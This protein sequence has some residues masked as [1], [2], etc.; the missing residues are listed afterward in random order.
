MRLNRKTKPEF[1][2]A[3]TV[4]FQRKRVTKQKDIFEC[5]NCSLQVI[6]VSNVPGGFVLRLVYGWFTAP[7]LQAITASQ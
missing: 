5:A 7:G 6:N 3:M 1:T 2:S 4:Y